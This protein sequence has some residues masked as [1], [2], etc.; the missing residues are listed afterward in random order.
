[1]RSALL[2]DLPADPGGRIQSRCR[3]SLF[4]PQT[5]P[6]MSLVYSRITAGRATTGFTPAYSAGET[7]SSP[8]YTF[9]FGYFPLKF[10][11]D[12]ISYRF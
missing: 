7:I 8:V 4:T 1:M 12:N 3:Q 11:T 9:L 6:L 2:R 5:I 10:R